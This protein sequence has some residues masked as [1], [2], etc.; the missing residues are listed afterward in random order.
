MW[1]LEYAQNP[2]RPNDWGPRGVV[3]E[4][5]GKWL[6]GGKE[7]GHPYEALMARVAEGP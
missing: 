1:F 3:L 7:Y 4:R 2:K 6:W 5:D